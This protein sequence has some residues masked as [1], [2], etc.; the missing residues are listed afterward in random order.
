MNQ[1]LSD[2]IQDVQ[3]DACFDTGL[4]HVHMKPTVVHPWKL[5]CTLHTSA[6]R[7][8]TESHSA[9]PGRHGEAGDASPER[10]RG[11]G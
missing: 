10:P 6:P 8:L 4:G 1:I 7:K 3:P 2:Q 5:K 9:I 11:L